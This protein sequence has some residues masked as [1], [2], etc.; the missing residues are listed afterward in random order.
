M[1]IWGE[2]LF[3]SRF[4][5]RILVDFQLFWHHVH[6][7]PP[8]PPPPPRRD[9]WKFLYKIQIVCRVHTSEEK[10]KLRGQIFLMLDFHWKVC[11][12]KVNICDILDFGFSARQHTITAFNKCRLA[13]WKAERSIFMLEKKFWKKK[14]FLIFFFLFASQ[15]S[16]KMS[17]FNVFFRGLNT[18]VAHRLSMTRAKILKLGKTSTWTYFIFFLFLF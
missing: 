6:I 4:F 9:S 2:K 3:F 17:V 18:F 16:S 13:F 7:I 1:K 15:I 10:N 5:S 12:K 14:I 8:T 11:S